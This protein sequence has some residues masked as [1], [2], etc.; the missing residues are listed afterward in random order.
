MA[1]ADPQPTAPPA[2]AAPQDAATP[3]MDTLGAQLRTR[4]EALVAELPGAGRADDVMRLVESLTSGNAM[5]VRQ[6]PVAAE[7]AL[8][9]TRD[10]DVGS[11]ALVRLVEED[12]SLSQALLRYANSA[13]YRTSSQACVSLQQA[14]QRVGGTGVHN[15]VLRAMVDGLLC[16]PGGRYQA[17]VEQVWSH[18]VRTAP[19]ARSL[20]PE[21]GLVPDHAFALGLLHDVGKLVIF[22]RIGT[23]RTALRRDIVVSDHALAILLRSLH[24]PLGAM[25]AAQW[26]LG[27]ATARAIAMHHRQPAPSEPHLASELLFLAERIDIAGVQ[28]RA[29]DLDAWWV[30][31]GLL[32]GKQRVE[33][34]LTRA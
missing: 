29:V 13:V 7:R 31:G 14:V 26:S 2:G 15:V 23:L 28:G 8:A 10:P 22:D 20:A 3:L 19:V 12:P 25:A 9:V 30:E 18:M 16:R 5:V 21:F 27:D 32:T 6:P 34:L 17:M 11:S 1:P 4:A 24:E 33:R